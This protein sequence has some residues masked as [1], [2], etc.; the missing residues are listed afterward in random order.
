MP[1]ITLANGKQFSADTSETIL[2]ASLRAGIVL[3]HSCKTG[4]CGSC[5]TRIHGGS[6]I[7]LVDE[8]GLSQAER[9]AGWILTCARSATSDVQL[10]TEDLGDIQVYPA[11]TLPCRIQKL[12]QLSTDVLRVT[13]R[14]PPSQQLDYLPGQYIDVIGQ[15]GLRRS[16]SVA[17][18]PTNDKSIELHIRQVREGAMSGYWFEEAKVNDLLRINGPLG[19]FFLRDVSGRDV[20]FLATGTGI[21]PVKAMLE[22]M[23]GLAEA[24][25]PRSISIY[26]GG[27]VPQDL[28]W[29][30][31]TLGLAVH[32]VPVLSRA[33]SSWKGARG[34][35]QQAVLQS[36]LKF[37]NAV[38]YACGSLAMIDS[39]RA[40]LVA[41]GLNE[42]R[43]YSDAFVS[44]SHDLKE[45][46]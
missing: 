39:A 43:F 28:Y 44:S 12:E 16:Y 5:K 2:D 23:A 27:R 37:G 33:D 46:S 40:E 11:K 38:V 22:G 7:P 13:L 9:E 26:W 1:I 41:A 19:T 24:S 10:D 29:D 3:E 25:L 31:E 36:G 35:V 8:I 4:R 18:A 15:N 6:S 20:I 14:L 45:S 17:N 34:H 30:P 21:A 42:R 32:Y